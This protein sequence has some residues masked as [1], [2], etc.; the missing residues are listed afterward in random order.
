MKNKNTRSITTV[1]PRTR[2][3][4]LLEV[5]LQPR[6]DGGNCHPSGEHWIE[7]TVDMKQKFPW[8]LLRY[9]ELQISYA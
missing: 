9:K 4:K 3:I 7:W 8:V 2:T 1:L 5:E 6:S